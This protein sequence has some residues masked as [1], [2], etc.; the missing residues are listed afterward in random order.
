MTLSSLASTRF[1]YKKR[2]TVFS[3][4]KGKTLSPAGKGQ[5]KRDVLSLFVHEKNGEA[6]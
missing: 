5:R 4:K 3:I 1:Y 2:W 6:L